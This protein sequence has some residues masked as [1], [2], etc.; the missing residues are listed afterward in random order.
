MCNVPFWQIQNCSR[1]CNVQRAPLHQYS[2]AITSTVLLFPPQST[3]AAVLHNHLHCFCFNPPPQVWKAAEV[4]PAVLHAGL[5]FAV[6]AGPAL[7]RSW[8][9]SCF[10]LP[11]G[12][13]LHL[14]GLRWGTTLSIGLPGTYKIQLICLGCHQ[15]CHNST[16]VKKLQGLLL[17][18]MQQ[19][20]CAGYKPPSWIN[21]SGTHSA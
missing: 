14:R 19:V 2:F 5:W 11:W 1:Q 21:A 16:A 4:C 17:N 13:G 20:I 15:L 9:R 7:S 18:K 3:H 12:A 6:K 8:G 10:R